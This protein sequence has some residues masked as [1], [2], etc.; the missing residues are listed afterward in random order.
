MEFPHLTDNDFPHIGNVNPYSS[1]PTFDYSRYDGMTAHALLCNVTWD[2]QYLHAVNWPD[3][4]TRDAWFASLQDVIS[5]EL[6]FTRLEMEHVSVDVPLDSARLYNYVVLSFPQLTLE[7]PI[8]N[9]Q[10]GIRT[11]FAFIDDYIYKAPSTTELVLSIDV[12]TTY[13]PHTYITGCMLDRGH[14]PMWAL[15]VAT[16]LQDP[17]ANMAMLATADDSFGDAGIVRDSEFVPVY[18]SNPMLIISSTIPHSQLNSLVASVSSAGSPASYYDIDSRNGEQVGVSGYVWSADGKT[19]SGARNP[20]NTA[21]ADGNLVSTWLYAISS[22]SD[23]E[24]IAQALPQLIT[25]AKACVVVPSSYVTLSQTYRTIGNSTIWTCTVSSDMHTLES[26]DIT[27]AAFG[28]PARYADITKLYT[29]PYAYLMVS[30]DLGNAVTVR[31]EDTHGTLEVK[32][33]LSATFGALSW[34]A[35]IDDVANTSGTVQYTIRTLTGQESKTLSGSD[36]AARTIPLGIPTYGLYLMASTVAGME[37]YADAQAK[38]RSAI[39]SYQSS[40]RS[41]N[42][43]A[44][45]AIAS[46]NTAKANADA[47]ANTAKTNADASADTV[48]SNTTRSTQNARDI[49]TAQ[50]TYAL[51]STASANTYTADCVNADVTFIDN[52]TIVA[53]ANETVASVGAISNIVVSSGMSVAGNMLSDNVSGAA[54]AAM[55]GVSQAVSAGAAYPV[56]ITSNSLQAAIAKNVALTKGVAAQDHAARNYGIATDQ[57][58][59]ITGRNADTADGN[60]TATQTTT[61]DNASR[62]QTTSKANAARTQA[63]ATG[64]ASASR[65]TSEENAKQALETARLNWQDSIAAQAAKAPVAFGAQSGNTL[66]DAYGR[67]GVHVRVMTQDDG[68]IARAGDTFI[69]YGYRYD[70]LWTIGELVPQTRKYSYW[71]SHDVFLASATLPNDIEHR[72]RSIFADGVTIWNDPAEIGEF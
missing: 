45:N 31:V 1:N 34:D 60:A 12:W 16:Y 33:Q 59:D 37:G 4:A 23:L 65:E 6:G 62:T 67:K 53:Q 55:G 38:R 28:Y 66:A 13:L 48:K 3:M 10:H 39:T 35:I 11:V 42:N 68:S 70:G 19:Y 69:R 47:S 58:T 52:S 44:A 54:M 51:S 25:S 63:T 72:L 64:N 21:H 32:D 56:S 40:M 46:A 15:D 71:Q 22:V 17:I 7:Q 49:A 26:F 43:G 14:A 24:V 5:C 18:S 27:K 29:F 36:F 20:A 8:R 41:A 61:K 9:E 30:D 57:N 2:E 50:N